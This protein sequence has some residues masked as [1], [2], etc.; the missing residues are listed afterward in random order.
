MSDYKAIKDNIRKLSLLIPTF[1][2]QPNFKEMWGIIKSTKFKGANFPSSSERQEAWD[3]FQKLIDKVKALQK[4][5]DKL[6][7]KKKEKSE[8]YSKK[9]IEQAHYA[10]PSSNKLEKI[11]LDV[12]LGGTLTGFKLMLKDL[13]E[14]FD[15]QKYELQEA[16]KRLKEGW[17]LFNECKD[18]MYGESKSRAFNALRETQEILNDAWEKHNTERQKAYDEYRSK[19]DQKRD[20]WLRKMESNINNLEERREKLESVLQHKESHLSD[21]RDKLYDANSDSYRSRVEG[22]ISEEESNIEDIREKLSN[23]RIWIEEAHEQINQ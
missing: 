19:Q 15:E 14:P 7:D 16:N 17:D 1:S 13:M 22:W 9:I 6:W 10:R 3:E 8:L 21:L 5:E 11:I 18:Q 4:E 23:I 20:N 12:A 2:G